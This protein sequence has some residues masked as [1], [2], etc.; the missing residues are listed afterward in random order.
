VDSEVV[1]D[2]YFKKACSLYNP[3]PLCAG[4]NKRPQTYFSTLEEQVSA[5]HPAGLCPP[6]FQLYLFPGRCFRPGCC[7]L[8]C[9]IITITPLRNAKSSG[10]VQSPLRDIGVTGYVTSGRGKQRCI[11]VP[12]CLRATKHYAFNNLF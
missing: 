3:F 8:R 2:F 6:S 11:S 10:D 5:D 4:G 12:H 1:Y 7:I 9:L